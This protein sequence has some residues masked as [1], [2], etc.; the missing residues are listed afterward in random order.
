[1]KVADDVIVAFFKSTE[2]QQ[3]SA[4]LNPLVCDIWNELKQLK[5]RKPPTDN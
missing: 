2:W 3:N 5:N 1:V 4:D